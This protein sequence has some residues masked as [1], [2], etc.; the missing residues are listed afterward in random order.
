M[1][2]ILPHIN[3]ANQ[4]TFHLFESIWIFQMAWRGSHCF[5]FMLHLFFSHD[6]QLGRGNKSKSELSDLGKREILSGAADGQFNA[7][8]G[9]SG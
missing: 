4:A 1:D 2:L 9:K 7:E 6:L 5:F 8:I 3:L